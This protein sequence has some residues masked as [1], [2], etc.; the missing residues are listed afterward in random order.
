[1]SNPEITIIGNIG[2]AIEKKLVGDSKKVE[3]RVIT[4]DRVKD[5]HG[6]WSDKNKSGW[7]VEAWDKTAE[8]CA[9][10][11]E[12]GDPVI[13]IGVIHDHSWTDRDGTSRIRQVVRISSIGL[14]VTRAKIK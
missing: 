12:I 13:I 2:T 3:F 1:M 9:D 7:S 6:N 4:S 5:E 11:L 14:D 10:H 8:R